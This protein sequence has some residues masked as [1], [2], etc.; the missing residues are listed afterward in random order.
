MG[1]PAEGGQDGGVG[2]RG[3]LSHA[4]HRCRVARAHRRQLRL[5]RA[6]RALRHRGLPLPLHPLELEALLQLLLLAHR[7]LFAEPHVFKVLP[8]A[9]V[10]LHG[11][12]EAFVRK[13]ADVR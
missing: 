10:L 1:A 11:G 4:P 5:H 6:L 9:A 7:L 8:H 3:S 2:G 13:V 12:G